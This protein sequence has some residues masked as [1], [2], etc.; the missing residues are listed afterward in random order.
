MEQKT[1]EPGALHGAGGCL[2]LSETKSPP[3]LLQHPRGM[4]SLPAEAQGVSPSPC[5][6][7]GCP[8]PLSENHPRGLS[9]ASLASVHPS[10]P[11]SQVQNKKNIFFYPG[12]FSPLFSQDTVGLLLLN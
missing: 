3:P 6:D 7:L 8:H 4:G 11:C 1:V 9:E 5:R 12:F 2:Q 10:G